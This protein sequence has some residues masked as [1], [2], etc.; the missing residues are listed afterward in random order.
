M[1]S[2]FINFIELQYYISILCLCDE[3]WKKGPKEL[4]CEHIDLDTESV[5]SQ[6]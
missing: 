4:N 2:N 1:Y 5:P 6:P 3:A